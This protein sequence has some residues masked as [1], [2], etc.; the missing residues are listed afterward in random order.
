[1][2]PECWIHIKNLAKHMDA[3]LNLTGGIHFVFA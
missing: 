2:Y 1:M 3:I